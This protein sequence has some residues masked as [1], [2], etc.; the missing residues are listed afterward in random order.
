MIAPL[1][2]NVA[3]LDWNRRSQRRLQGNVAIALALALVLALALCW[4]GGLRRVLLPGRRLQE[5]A[6]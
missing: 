4:L 5:L 1:Q 6:T 3:I 2:G